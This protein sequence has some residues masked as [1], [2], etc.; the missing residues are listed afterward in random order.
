[1]ALACLDRVGLDQASIFKRL[2]I[3]RDGRLRQR[4]LAADLVDVEPAMRPQKLQDPHA[5]RRCEPLEDVGGFLRIDRQEIGLLA[6]VGCLTLHEGEVYIRNL[7]ILHAP[8]FRPLCRREGQE[9]HCVTRKPEAD[10]CAAIFGRQ[11]LGC[12]QGR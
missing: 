5:N 2:H 7:D 9:R 11:G 12:A 10:R 8:R 3:G 1:M 6:P 4:E